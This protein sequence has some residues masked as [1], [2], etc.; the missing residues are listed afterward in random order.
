[1][2]QQIPLNPGRGNTPHLV[3][4]SRERVL[5][6]QRTETPALSTGSPA[7]PPLCPQRPPCAPDSPAGPPAAKAAS[8]GFGARRGLCPGCVAPVSV[9]SG[10]DEVGSRARAHVSVPKP[11]QAGLGLIRS[12]LVPALP[13][14]GGDSPAAA[15]RPRP[16]TRCL[17]RRARRTKCCSL[18][19]ASAAPATPSVLTCSLKPDIN[20]HNHGLGWTGRDLRDQPVPALPW[21]GTPSPSSFP[22]ALSTPEGRGSASS[23]SW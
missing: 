13:R 22:K 5:A 9:Q 23:P 14:T 18:S 1:M 7:V 19:V 6:P 20:S 8:W 15:A 2:S 3:F 16:G 17:G 12:P 11:G 10:A 21:A 4:W